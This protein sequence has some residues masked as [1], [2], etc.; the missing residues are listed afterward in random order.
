[1]SG[2]VSAVI[3]RSALAAGLL[4]AGLAATSCSTF[5]RASSVAEF[6]SSKLSRTDLVALTGAES[7]AGDK[8]RAAITRWLTLGVLG[9]DTRGISSADELTARLNKAQTTVA[10]PFMDSARAQYSKGLDGSP[11]VCLRAIPLAAPN[12]P[13]T[14][15][16]AIAGGT[17]FADAATKYSSDPTLAQSGGVIPGDTQ[18]SDCLAPKT[19]NADLLKL[20]T[21]AKPAIGTPTTVDFNGTKIIFL[22]RPFDEIPEIN[23]DSLVGTEIQAAVSKQIAAAKI[24]VNPQYGKWDPSALSVVALGQS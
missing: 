8:A 22:L 21:E 19:L 12:T 23:K 7:G 14:V 2:R 1:M 3:R 6:G 4:L 20:L 17:S 10:A 5:D 15:L 13:D 9:G 18:G 16:A 24:Y 11:I